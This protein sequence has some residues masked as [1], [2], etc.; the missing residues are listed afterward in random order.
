MG[1]TSESRTMSFE[2]FP[3]FGHRVGHEKV[4]DENEKSPRAVRTEFVEN[5]HETRLLKPFEG[6]GGLPPALA[7]L[8]REFVLRATP[9]RAP[10][11][12]ER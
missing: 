2:P 7:D 5:L 9:L 6:R 3:D 12:S 11:V 8:L 1:G 4:V 10:V